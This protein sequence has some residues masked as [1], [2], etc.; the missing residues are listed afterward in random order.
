M[1]PFYTLKPD[2]LQEPVM[3]TTLQVYKIDGNIDKPYRVIERCE[4][5][6]LTHAKAKKELARTGG[7]TQKP[8]YME[9]MVAENAPLLWSPQRMKKLK[10][11]DLPT[12]PNTH[13]IDTIELQVIFVKESVYALEP[14]SYKNVIATQDRKGFWFQRGIRFVAAAQRLGIHM[15]MEY[16]RMRMNIKFGSK[17]DQ[18]M[19]MKFNKQNSA[20]ITCKPIEEAIINIWRQIT[21]QWISGVKQTRQAPKPPSP[22]RPKAPL[23]KALSPKAPSSKA[24]SSKAP[25]PKAPSPKH[26]PE[27]DDHNSNIII[28]EERVDSDI[29]LQISDNEL[30][31]LPPQPPLPPSPLPPAPYVQINYEGESVHVWYGRA[32]T[33]DGEIYIDGYGEKE[34]LAK[35]LRAYK[36]TA[37]DEQFIDFVKRFSQL[38]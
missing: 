17:L 20:S 29:D 8:V 16:E 2:A 31:P 14:D 33:L 12:E 32:P 6:R 23:P 27:S 9:Y 21:G 5:N 4:H 36:E 28:D 34:A 25:S 7:S 30:E 26:T 38:V 10:S 24:P 19:G 37:S 13:L 18:E 22:P 15:N 3:R 1:D 11:V 35:W